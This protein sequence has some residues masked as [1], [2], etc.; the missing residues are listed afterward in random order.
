MYNFYPEFRGNVCSRHAVRKFLLI[1]KIT[2]L[3]LVAAILHV[4][5]SSLAQK[6]SLTE[7]NVPL[8]VIFEKIH[9]QTGYDF[10]FTGS[11]LR[12]AKPITINVKKRR[13]E[14]FAKESICRSAV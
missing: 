9:D 5:A 10:L 12:N 14:G 3:I 8:P 4:S 7:K 11:D 13:P 2:T 6:V 1:M